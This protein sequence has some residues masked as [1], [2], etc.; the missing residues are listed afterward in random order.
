MR[1]IVPLLIAIAPVQ[2]LQA[3]STDRL[4]YVLMTGA[5]N[6]SMMSGSVDDLNRAEALRAGHAPMLYVR[7][8]GVAY[9]IR[10]PAI[11]RRADAIVRPQHELAR[12]QGDLGRQQGE[13]GR[14]QGLLGAEQGRL[15]AMM[16]SARLRDTGDLGRQQGELG[17]RQAELGAQQAAL[18][19]QQ[20]ALGREQARLGEL[21][22]PQLRALIA[23]AVRRGMAQRVD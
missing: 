16:V 22:K 14:R 5:G 19:R 21:S 12:R 2:A 8:D 6:D 9:V 10:D 1:W 17:R 23:D 4:S 7:Q 13:L 20:E 18:G 3:D 15:A 11:L